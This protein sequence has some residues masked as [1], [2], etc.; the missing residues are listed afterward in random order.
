MTDVTPVPAGTSTVVQDPK[1]CEM[2]DSA[3]ETM[4]TAEKQHVCGL[5]DNHDG[6]HGSPLKHLR[7]NL[8]NVFENEP[9][10]QGSDGHTSVLLPL[11]ENIPG[12]TRKILFFIVVNFLYFAEFMLRR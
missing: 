6:L 3:V 11:I 5:G 8:G 9:A 12:S 1:Q 2:G 7:A 4:Q 10:G